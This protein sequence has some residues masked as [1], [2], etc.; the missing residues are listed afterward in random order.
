MAELTMAEAAV[1]THQLT[2]Q[3]IAEV[4]LRAAAARGAL[5]AR[6]KGK[7]W[8]TT[9]TELRKYLASRPAHFKQ[10]GRTDVVSGGQRRVHMATRSQPKK[11]NVKV[12]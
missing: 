11:K 7:D 10:G 9:D 3:E 2:G 12:R 8:V 6:K 1:K 5:K 4:S